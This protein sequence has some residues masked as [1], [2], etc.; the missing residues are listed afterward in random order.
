MDTNNLATGSHR[1][2]NLGD[3]AVGLRLWKWCFALLLAAGG[4]V[5]LSTWGAKHRAA[6]RFEFGPPLPAGRVQ[7]QLSAGGTGDTMA[8]LA[9]DGSLWAWGGTVYNLEGIFPGH[10]TRSTVPVRI[11]SESDWLR[12]AVADQRVLAL[13]TN[14]TLW[15][16]GYSH[17]GELLSGLEF[18]IVTPAQ[19]STDTDWAD[20]CFSYHHVLALKR[21]GSLWAWGFN[22]DGQVGNG[23]RT[24]VAV[25]TQVTPGRT[26]K[27]VVGGGFSSYG[28]QTDGT[29]WGWGKDMDPEPAQLD[30]GTNWV[31][32]AGLSSGV[33]ALKTDGTLWVSGRLAGIFGGGR[34]SAYPGLVQIEKDTDWREIYAGMACFLARKADGTW[35]GGGGNDQGQLG[36]GFVSTEAVQP[37]RRLPQQFEPWAFLAAGRN[38][39]VM[40]GRDG[41]VW[42]WGIRAGEP[43]SLSLVDRLR[44]WWY[45]RSLTGRAGGF[46]CTPVFVHDRKPH[47]VWELPASVK[48]ELRTNT[49]ASAKAGP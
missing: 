20:V 33:L 32:L 16:W 9:P 45:L 48:S 17:A 22:K 24:N 30:S 8:L 5:L 27:S 44:Y 7:P 21:N 34:A 42:S 19:L 15:G 35:W 2:F 10:S 23:S 14:G 36:L 25:V 47:F 1:T 49:S 43:E 28:I 46:D 11:G 40:L 12:V 13:K 29:L 26:W 39:T 3:S 4:I 38:T 31:V 6:R 37:P 18:R 41:T